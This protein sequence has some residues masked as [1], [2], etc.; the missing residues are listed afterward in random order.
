MQLTKYLST[1]HFSI[2]AKLTI[3]SLSFSLPIAVLFYYTVTTIEEP[4]QFAT[5]ELAGNEYQRPLERLLEHVGLHKLYARRLLVEGKQWEASVNAEEAK[6]EAAF[7]QLDHI[8]KRHGIILQFTAEGLE[9]RERLHARPENVKRKWDELR[10]TQATL[11]P[12]VSDIQHDRILSD[13]R[14]MITHAGDNSNLILD[15]DL[16]SYYLMDLTLLTLP[17][18]QDRLT[19]MITEG[20]RM[21]QEGKQISAKDRVRLAELVVLLQ[22]ADFD[23]AVK[24]ANDSLRED[25]L[26][27]G[28]SPSLQPSLEPALQRFKNDTENFLKLVGALAQAEDAKVSLDDYV[29]AGLRAREAS[30]LL[31]SVTIAELD[32]LLGIRIQHFK[33]VRIIALTLTA[34]ALVVSLFLVYV[35]SRSI[36]VPIR[37]CVEGMQALAGRDLTHKLTLIGNGELGQMALAVNQAVDGVSEAVG[38]MRKNTSVLTNASE[39]MTTASQIMSANAEETSSQANVVASAAEEVSKSVQTVAMASEQMAAAIKEVTRQAQEAARVSVEGVKMA[40]NTNATV[41]KLGESSQSIGNVVKVI[42]SIAEQTNLLAL[43]ATIEAA[44]AG[45]FGKGFAVVANEVK[46]LAKQT[47]Q[48]TEVIG[49]RIETIQ[50]EIQAAVATIGQISTIINQINGTQNAIARAVEEQNLVTRE[51]GRNLT[52]AAKGTSEIARN[53][54]GVAEA[55][56]N[57]SEGAHKT[58]RAAAELA[59]MATLFK[60]LVANFKSVDGR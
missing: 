47:A 7:K 57:T 35:V 12:E 4:I 5:L 54:T 17:Q 16:D 36:T 44:R 43:N 13:V 40:Q 37:R 41:A 33:R 28:V 23:R 51:I 53:I 2:A 32:K 15:P 25:P 19:T 22:R 1:R 24:S 49:Q 58:E 46:E 20:V 38:A 59:R 11:K 30:F 27:Y 60:E 21:L 3:I 9:K 56:H 39:E 34:L 55:A 18:M 31:W 42:T 10:T 45:E 52:E 29:S 8:D 26:A 48:A 14:D 50:A 6:I